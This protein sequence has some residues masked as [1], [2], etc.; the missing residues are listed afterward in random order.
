MR[1]GEHG[2]LCEALGKIAGFS[3]EPRVAAVY[4]VMAA[5]AVILTGKA[6]KDEMKNANI[7]HM[8]SLIELILS[9]VVCLWLLMFWRSL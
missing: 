9:G 2:L 7:W 5:A 3:L 4:E 6:V 8:F 1:Y